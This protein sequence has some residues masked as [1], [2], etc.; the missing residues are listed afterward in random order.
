M[1]QDR[2]G[3]AG[4]QGQ[5]QERRRG[6]G[7]EPG[8]CVH[9]CTC[10]CVSAWEAGMVGS[11]PACG[12]T[13]G[14]HQGQESAFAPNVICWGASASGLS[15]DKDLVPREQ[16]A[17]IISPDNHPTTG[18]TGLPPRGLQW[19]KKPPKQRQPGVQASVGVGGI[20]RARRTEN[21]EGVDG[22][23]WAWTWA[24]SACPGQLASA[25]PYPGVLG[26]EP[27]KSPGAVDGQTDGQA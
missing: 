5:R 12:R 27:L 4:G 23:W 7:L 14:P 20:F 3:R 25:A 11:L 9:V 24:G 13:C 6:G 17:F 15:F 22:V 1:G 16:R 19:A 26:A 8:V 2:D 10:V 21:R 18:R